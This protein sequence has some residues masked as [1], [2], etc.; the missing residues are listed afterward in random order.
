MKELFQN[1]RDFWKIVLHSNNLFFVFALIGNI[2]TSSVLPFPAIILSKKVFDLFAMGGTLKAYI[3]ICLVWISISFLLYFLDI[4]LEGAVRVSSERVISQMATD[5]SRKSMYISY[6]LQSHPQTLELREMAQ[7]VFDGG[8]FSALINTF[9][10]MVVAGVRLI[11]VASMFLQLGIV[12]IVTV[13]ILSLVNTLINNLTKKVEYEFRVKVVPLNR[14]VKYL[15]HIASNIEYGKEI[16]VNSFQRLTTQKIE[17]AETEIFLLVK[18]MLHNS[19]NA[20]RLTHTTTAIQDVVVYFVL[21]YKVLLA[22]TLSIGDFSLYFGSINTFKSALVSIMSEIGD[23]RIKGRY[24]GHYLS[25]M[26]L[27]EESQDLEKGTDVPLIEQL[28]FENVSFRYPGQEAYS[29]KDLSFTIRKGEKVAFVGTNGAGKSTVVKL[30]LR[31]YKPTE[32]RILLNGIDINEMSCEEYLRQFAVVFQDYKLFAYTIREN[33][34]KE[35]IGND[36]ELNLLMRDIG[37]YE[38]IACLPNKY[39]T[40]YSRDFDEKGVEFSGGESQKIAIARAQYKNSQVII[41]DEPTAA[42]D[43]LAEAEI[44]Q[45]FDLL[46]KGKSAIYIS[47]RLSSCRFCDVI[48]TMSNGRIMEKGSH[49][50]LLKNDGLYAQMFQAQAQYYVEKQ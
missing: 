24:L 20:M 5:F 8:T 27:P 34:S 23:M 29:V 13:V 22:K 38:R 37:L 15:Q 21:G 9:K 14:R 39:E 31:L 28:M 11:I 32:G 6:E 4:T 40:M 2:V 48:Y 1:L 43:P 16:R 3:Y 12:T 25:Y 47:H 41:M 44:Y 45:K 7:K 35:D 10:P 19:M 30:M 46:T 50:Q 33:I 49:E 17:E 36:E 26:S 42:L 18:K